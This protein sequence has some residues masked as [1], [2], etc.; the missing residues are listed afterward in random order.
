VSV[1]PQELLALSR[2]VR[3]DFPSSG[4]KPFRD[5]A[6]VEPLLARQY[7]FLAA[8]TMLD[9]DEATELAANIWRVWIIARDHAGGRAFLATVLDDR[10]ASRSRWRALALYGDGL[11]AW[12]Q[13]ERED[14]RARNGE[15]LELAAEVD[16]PEAL[17]LARLGASRV[18]LEDGD[19]T[20]AYELA[21]GARAAAA[22]LGDAMAQGSLHMHAQA[23]RLAGNYD[24]AAALF[25]ESLA[26]NRRIGSPGMVAVELHNLGH[27]EIHRGNVD[28][29]EECF[30]EVPHSDDPN[31]EAMSRLN[32][33]TVAFLRGD[34]DRARALLEG[35]DALFAE[36]PMAAVAIDDRFELDWLRDQLR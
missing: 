6:D 2:G 33:A 19:Y 29:A 21:A 31:S 34:L 30:K 13:G 10:P 12:W 14:S 22:P 11:F 18:A 26:L 32:E 7:D 15:A 8:A 25:Q 17:S 35:A 24:E 9:V 20:R 36:S 16:D 27:V 4:G 3:W 1:D 28:A 5:R 23:T